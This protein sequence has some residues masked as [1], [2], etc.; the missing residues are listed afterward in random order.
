M[1]SPAKRNKDKW[2]R[3]LQLLVSGDSILT[4]L[5]LLTAW[6]LAGAKAV[7]ARAVSYHLKKKEIALQKKRGT[8]SSVIVG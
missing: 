6:V 8:V 2:R 3:V 7:V 5:R 4:A 1:W